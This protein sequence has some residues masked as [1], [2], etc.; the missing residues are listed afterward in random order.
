MRFILAFILD[1][2]RE[3]LALPIVKIRKDGFLGTIS[4]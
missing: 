2:S 4:L 3:T 1:V